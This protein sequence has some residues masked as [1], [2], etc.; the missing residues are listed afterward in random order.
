MQIIAH[1]CPYLF[2]GTEL[3]LVN[4][5]KDN[6]DMIKEGVLNVLAKD[7]GIIHQ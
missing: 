5:L 1:L 7:G 6:N 4:L 3:E 2:S